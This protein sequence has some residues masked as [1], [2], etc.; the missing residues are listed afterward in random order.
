[1]APPILGRVLTNA[2]RPL[3]ARRERL[4][5]AFMTAPDPMAARR[6]TGASARLARVA[7]ILAALAAAGLVQAGG[8]GLGGPALAQSGNASILDKIGGKD[9]GKPKRMF[10]ESDQVVYDR[11][12][13]TVTALGNVQIKYQG[14]TLT[15]QKVTFYRNTKRVVAEGAAK[16]VEPGG[17]LLSAA[18][19][20]VT[21]NFREGFI[22]AL[23]VDSTERSR[24]VAESAERKDANITVFQNGVYTA[25]QT[26][27]VDPDVPPFWKIKAA[28]IIHNQTEKTVY[29]EDA[30]LE[31][32]G[33][34]IAYVP[35]FSH[36]DPSVTR[37][38][39]FLSPGFLASTSLGFGVQT[40][41]FWAPATNWDVTFAPTALS[42]QGLLGDVELR[43]RT[44]TGKWSVRA[45]GIN[46]L[47][48]A[49]FAGTSGDRD[50][51]GAIFTK[52]EFN[53]NEQWKYGWDITIPS[54]RRFIPDYH[55]L[56][57]D[58]QEAVS[59]IYL[60]GMGER[61]YFDARLYQFSIFE[62]DSR[63]TRDPKILLPAYVGLGL[64][65]KQP[66]VMPV[67][68]YNYIHPDP[69][70]GGELAANF[71]LTSLSR[72][73]TD[74]DL[75][76]QV[77]GIAGTFSRISLDVDWRRQVI[78]SF[79]QV[80]TPFASV[81]G[82][83]FFSQNDS[84]G[85]TAVPWVSDGT[86]ARV[87]P[88]IGVEYRFPFI[89]TSSFGNHVIEPIAQLIASSNEQ[90]VGHL[91]NEDAQSLVFD[92]STLFETD[93]FS[94]FDRTEGGTRANV[95]V[96]Y[97]F[98]PNGG[99][100]ISALVGQSYHL[101]GVNSFADP[102]IAKLFIMDPRPLTAYGSGL[103]TAQSDFVTALYLDTG[104]G[105][106]VGANGRFDNADLK[107]NRMEIQA[108]G[109]TGPLTGTVTY[110]YLKTP[111]ILYDLMPPKYVSLLEPDRSE[112]QGAANLR[113]AETWR[114]FGG[115]R[116]DIRNDFIVSNTVGVGFDNDSFSA[117]IAY[118]EDTDRANSKLAGKRIL[119]DQ[120]V[121]F[122]FG[123]RT[124]GDGSIS[125]SL[126]R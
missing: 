24:F 114:V 52:G 94:G 62:D 90:Y 20:D 71:N 41:F 34:P 36:P 49:A 61:N 120:V 8:L 28:K 70:A 121:Y 99:G 85:H 100:S 51:R 26:C 115:I 15:A 11:D 112:I 76:R 116:Y 47:D 103:D 113:L 19:M 60:T 77:W 110:A 54:D 16:L 31:L 13:S 87:T 81:K 122:R 86:L 84:V 7:W 101:A 97:T 30:K 37:K 126:L 117:S 44:E 50:F 105:F 38:T 3:A 23:T 80:F 53:I 43:N 93:K 21:D 109:V 123:L 82:D 55:L 32:A 119:T 10:L 118:A 14:Y 68:D 111:S 42:R 65:D 106:R 2:R 58:K 75:A 98:L 96:R 124:V 39:G 66:V 45:V 125:N 88:T 18:K 104:K 57:I 59:T 78:D 72:D 40:P 74:L 89:G 22:Q 33:V 83:L 17:N 64:Q 1:M 107:L 6:R 69:V 9:D 35:Y 73:R 92:A 67:I 63:A 46:Q 79:G 29:Y 12:G 5:C 27:M 4:A 56:P 102:A 48:P 95:G 108:T 91:S 25:C